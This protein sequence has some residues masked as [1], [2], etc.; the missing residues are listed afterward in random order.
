LSPAIEKGKAGGPIKVSWKFYIQ[1]V[2]W[3]AVIEAPLLAWDVSEQGYLN[4]SALFL[5]WFHMPGYLLSY[6]MLAP[7]RHSISSSAANRI[8]YSLIFFFQAILIGTVIYI[9]RRKGVIRSDSER[10]G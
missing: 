7:F 2:A 3:G 5:M 4:G 9:F 8:G 6:H 1:C 10:N